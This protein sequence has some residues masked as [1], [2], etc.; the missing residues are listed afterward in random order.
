[1]LHIRPDFIFI[2]YVEMWLW[3]LLLLRNLD[4]IDGA[5]RRR[6][7]WHAMMDD[8][9]NDGARVGENSKVEMAIFQSEFQS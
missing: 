2:D 3:W 4:F 8:M 6:M 7:T 5:Y 1:M 9:M